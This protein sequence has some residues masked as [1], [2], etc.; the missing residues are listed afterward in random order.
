MEKF[1]AQ[2][3]IRVTRIIHKMHIFLVTRKTLILINVGW[4][5][6]CLWMVR[7]LNY[8][9]NPPISI[10]P[11]RDHTTTLPPPI[12]HSKTT[13]PQCHTSACCHTNLHQLI[14]KPGAGTKP[15]DSHFRTNFDHQ[16]CCHI[17][18]WQIQTSPARCCTIFFLSRLCTPHPIS[19]LWWAC[20]QIAQITSHAPTMKDLA[21]TS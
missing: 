13:L 16:H 7:R 12:P 15:T 1:F 5:P 17:N 9:G 19:I 2:L 3:G 11:L 10:P 4:V 6:L 8:A 18:L 14:T 20:L 21:H